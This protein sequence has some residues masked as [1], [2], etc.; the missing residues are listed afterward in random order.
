MR[1]SRR[2]HDEKQRFV[3]SGL[4]VGRTYT[5]MAFPSSVSTTS[6]F[7]SSFVGGVGSF[8]A[9]GVVD[10]EL[11]DGT[12]FDGADLSRALRCWQMIAPEHEAYRGR[13]LRALSRRTTSKVARL[14]RAAQAARRGTRDR[15]DYL[16]LNH[17]VGCARRN[18]P[19]RSASPCAAAS[20]SASVAWRATWIAG[21]A[22]MR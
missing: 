6:P 3:M 11:I 22:S 21:N 5:V 10:L 18:V 14:T 4:D 12:A 16:K 17:C 7:R 9:D 8:V 20:R 15:V 1:D 2:R 13:S 19:T